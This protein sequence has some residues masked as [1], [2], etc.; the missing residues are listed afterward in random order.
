MVLGPQSVENP[1]QASIHTDYPSASGGSVT[2]GI[3]SILAATRPWVRIC[4]IFGFVA[5]AFTCLAAVMLIFFSGT[6]GATATA[7]LWMGAFYLLFAVASGIPSFKLWRY[8]A[9]ISRLLAS[10]SPDDLGQAMGQLR[11]FWRSFGIAV[12]ILV[13]LTVLAFVAGMLAAVT[14]RF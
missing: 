3:V 10:G 5:T 8:G 14:R 11:G 4:A 13:G 7:N 6:R 12:L 1:Y 9:M 2:P